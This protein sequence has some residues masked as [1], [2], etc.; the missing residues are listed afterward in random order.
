MVTTAPILEERRLLGELDRALDALKR[1]AG[2]EGHVIARENEL[3]KDERADAIIE[4][5]KDGQPHRYLVEAKTRVDRVATLGHLK[6]RQ[7]LLDDRYLLF[8]PYITT[9][10]AKQCRDLH[11]EFLDM[12]GNTY[13]EAPGLYVFITGEKPEGLT[14]TIMGTGGGGT[15]TAHRVVFALLC[16]PELLNAPYREIVDAAGVALGAIGWVFF[17]LEGRGLIAGKQKKHFSI[18]PKF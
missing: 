10:I 4:I 3:R 18:L 2:L 8:A 6:A 12:A 5:T 15:A 13:L 14:A 7:N 11:I 1:N 16:K 17:D 9:T